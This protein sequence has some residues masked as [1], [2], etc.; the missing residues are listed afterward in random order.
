MGRKL[1]PS[2]S[3]F[4]HEEEGGI[5]AETSGTYLPKKAFKYQTKH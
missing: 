5:S 3:R 1:L 2:L 4:C